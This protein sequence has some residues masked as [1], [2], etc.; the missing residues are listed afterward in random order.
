MTSIKKLNTQLIN[1]EGWIW[2]KKIWILKHFQGEK[3]SNKKIRIKFNREKRLKEDGIVRKKINFRNHLKNK[4]IIR[5]KSN[6]W[7][8]Q[9]GMKLPKDSSLINYSKQNN[10]NLVDIIHAPAFFL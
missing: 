10:P 8:N 6:T 4:K 9:K 2:K 7:K 5:T 1:I 3:S